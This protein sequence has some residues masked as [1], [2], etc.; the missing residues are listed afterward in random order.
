MPHPVPPIA[1][2]RYKEIGLVEVGWSVPADAAANG[3]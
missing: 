1:Y 3:A 2:L